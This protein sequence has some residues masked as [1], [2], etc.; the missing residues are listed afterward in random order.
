[1]S[2]RLFSFNVSK[3]CYD[4]T[5]GYHYYGRQLSNF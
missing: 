5:Q 4:Y 3:E 1:M 2:L